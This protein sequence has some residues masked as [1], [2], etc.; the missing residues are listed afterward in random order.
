MSRSDGMQAATATRGSTATIDLD[1]YVKRIGYEGGLVPTIETLQSLQLR[2]AES[3]PFENLNPLL[4]WPV[5]LDLASLEQKMVRD[6]RG[7]YCFEQNLLFKHAL[8]AL[9]FRVT[10]LAARVLWNQPERVVA[11]R[12]HMLLLVDLDGRRYVTDVGFGGVTL[13]GPL[14]L[15]PD[16]EQTTPH[17]PFRLV[18]ADEEFIEQVKI[19]GHWVS[20]YRFNLSEQFLPDYEM[21]NWYLSTHP[22]SRFVTG[23]L[24]ARPAPDRRYGLLNNQLTIHYRNGGKERRMIT[25]LADMRET[26]ERDF[27]IALPGSPALDATLTRVIEK[28]PA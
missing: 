3:I 19:G 4:G 12:S 10:G 1:A 15:E 11:P 7:G 28:V 8:E 26:L 5:R 17:E 27:R 21:A 6:G 14:R 13:T 24:A 2:H 23:L 20:L 9:G 25:S 18:K 22:A 16:V